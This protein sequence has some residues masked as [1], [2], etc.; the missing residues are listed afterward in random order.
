MF[1]IFSVWLDIYPEEGMEC[2]LY[3]YHCQ[4][5]CCQI[6]NTSGN[7]TI[8]KFCHDSLNLLNSVKIHLGKTL[9]FVTM[10]FCNCSSWFIILLDT[11][12]SDIKK[13]YM[14][15]RASHT[16]NFS[17]GKHSWH[18]IFPLFNGI[19]QMLRIGN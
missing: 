12:L 1:G 7:I 4:R 17:A 16:C 9:M 6:G 10:D 5:I 15:I 14:K 2:A 8:F 11:M 18:C 19:L 3:Y 13:S